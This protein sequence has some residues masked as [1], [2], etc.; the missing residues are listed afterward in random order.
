MEPLK[1]M[2]MNE[3]VREGK[4]LGRIVSCAMKIAR[5]SLFS[6]AVVSAPE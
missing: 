6:F 5:H 4:I 1:N 2:Y 3:V